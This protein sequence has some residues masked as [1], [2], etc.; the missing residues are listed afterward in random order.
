MAILKAN[1]DKA[2]FVSNT[3]SQDVLDGDWV[4][5]EVITK[6]KLPEIT[7]E[8]STTTTSLESFDVITTGDTLR[9]LDGANI[10][11]RT[12]GTVT[13]TLPTNDDLSF[14]LLTGGNATPYG[15]E[16]DATQLGFSFNNDGTKLFVFQCDNSTGSFV[17]RILQYTCSTA[18]NT[19]T[20]GAIVHSYI[21]ENT[22]MGIG[23]GLYI[24]PDGLHIAVSSYEANDLVYIITLGTA[25]DLST[26]SSSVSG[27]TGGT[28]DGA[29]ISF[30]PD[31][32]KM[33]LSSTSSTIK[34]YNLVAPWDLTNKVLVS[35]QAIASIYIGIIDSSGRF[36]YGVNKVTEL[37]TPWEISTFIDTRAISLS[38]EPKASIGNKIILGT[39]ANPYNSYVYDITPT[40]NTLYQAPLNVAGT[41]T[42]TTNIPTK[43]FFNKTIDTTLS[44]EATGK[45][46]TSAREY[47]TIDAITAS[48]GSNIVST[49]ELITGGRI[50]VDGEDA[51]GGSVSFAGAINYD[52]LN[53]GSNIN[54]TNSDLTASAIATIANG[55]NSNSYLTPQVT[56]GTIEA[57]FT[58]G[59]HTGE[60]AIGISDINTYQGFFFYNTATG[61]GYKS[62]GTKNTNGNS[63][64]A[65]GDSFTTNDVI[66]CRY[67][68]E[69][70]E[71][72]FFKND[73]SQ[74]VAYTL[75]INTPMYFALKVDTIGDSAVVTDNIRYTQLLPNHT[76]TT[77]PT[78]AYRKGGEVLDFIDGEITV[79]ATTTTTQLDSRNLITTGDSLVLLDGV[80]VVERTAGTVTTTVVG[81]A[82][83]LGNTGL[84]ITLSNSDLTMT[85]SSTSWQN[86]N[87][88]SA[89]SMSNGEYYFEVTIGDI[90]G[91]V[92]ISSN[93]LDQS[94]LLGYVPNSFNYYKTGVKISNSTQTAYGATFTTGDIIGCKYSTINNNIEFF[95]NGA[96]QGIAFSNVVE[97]PMYA[98]ATVYTSGS[99]ATFNFGA[100]AFSNQPANT[101][102]VGEY[103]AYQAPITATT[104]IPTKAWN[105]DG[106]NPL[107]YVGTNPI[108]GLITTGDTIQLDGASEV[109]CSEVVEVD[110]SAD[111][112]IE[113]AIN[114]PIDN[115]APIQTF[116]TNNIAS[117]YDM[118][119]YC[120]TNFVSGVT[121]YVKLQ[122]TDALTGNAG[123]II[124]A[125][126]STTGLLDLYVV[127]TDGSTTT[128]APTL[129][130]VTSTVNDIEFFA[131]TKGGTLYVETFDGGVKL[132]SVS[133]ALN[134]SARTN[135][136]TTYARIESNIADIVAI[137][138]ATYFTDI[139]E[140][141][142]S[143]NRT[144]GAISDIKYQYT[145]TIPTQGAAPTSAKVLDRSATPTVA[146]DTFDGVDT[147]TKTY[148]TV[149]KTA[150]Y[151][152]Y[153]FVGDTDVEVTQFNLNQNMEP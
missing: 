98:G 50:V 33:Y 144:T 62:T 8:A 57:E 4:D 60:I 115:T 54:L 40:L 140:F 132:D 38:G 78:V 152:E 42:A 80:N 22:S 18:W 46:L 134:G 55:T 88:Y 52:A 126:I 125:L 94:N 129:S 83:T 150:R 19:S 81:A 32:T 148:N 87:A 73:I 70:G 131:L 5:H 106:T 53:S 128:V 77:K 31:G 84:S 143:T 29:S 104:N 109:V 71:L 92:G 39:D 133:I 130:T 17:S 7:L 110:A 66:K 30:K 151:V 27:T 2:R 37:A 89:D 105:T 118:A 95:K 107:Q 149:T 12:A 102:K 99:T 14:S 123:T 127:A 3:I 91:S 36:V 79:D 113:K 51:I 45:C 117:S 64:T 96:S 15:A 135:I 116:T 1:K 138:D 142:N 121:T 82:T 43:A 145:A 13:T 10:V 108:S 67:T 136:A 76:G 86:G 97:I 48:D 75:A 120:K 35:T 72:E 74:G 146:S 6:Y 26:V 124:I 111:I 114:V 90:E 25:F 20:A 147:F 34:Q 23:G 28:L 93:N 47:I 11:E 59:S 119:F 122:N 49:T 153:G 21:V 65:Y 68:F 44:A 41:L 24:A 137:S 16:P 69:S 9:V 139:N 56:S 103:I 112:E 58:I 141:V 100:T 61:Y 101:I 63:N 85:K